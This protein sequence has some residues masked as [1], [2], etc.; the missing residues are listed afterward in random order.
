MRYYAAII[1]T[2]TESCYCVVGEDDQGIATVAGFRVVDVPPPAKLRGRA[3][4][5]PKRRTFWERFWGNQ[6]T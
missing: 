2:G 3:P 4:E 6:Q 5:P 1:K